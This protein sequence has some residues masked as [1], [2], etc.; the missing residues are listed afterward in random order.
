MFDRKAWDK[1]Y[2]KQNR[3]AFLKRTKRWR[4]RN[5]QRVAVY[6]K[7]YDKI[8]YRENSETIVVQRKEYRQ[9]NK[10][11]VNKQAKQYRDKNK[12]AVQARIK[13]WRRTHKGV[14]RQYGRLYETRRQEAIPKW[15]TEQDLNTMNTLYESSQRLSKET[16]IQ[17]AVDH[18]VPLRGRT[19]CGLHVPS[20]LCVITKSENS[21][22]NNL[23]WPDKP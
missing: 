21:K 15:L 9:N 10:A 19:V 23:I 18:I 7:E 20:N 17:H 2:R 8:Y 1:Q 12:P 5:K 22:K 4:L 6:Q 13:N 16:E 14:C 3:A 11:L